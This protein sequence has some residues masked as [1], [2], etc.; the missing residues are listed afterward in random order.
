MEIVRRSV[1]RV[2]RRPGWM[3]VGDDDVHVNGRARFYI[4]EKEYCRKFNSNKKSFEVPMSSHRVTCY[5]NLKGVLNTQILLLNVYKKTDRHK[6][7]SVE[8]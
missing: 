2:H 7:P 3:R 1:G 5:C 4:S 8:V 6:V